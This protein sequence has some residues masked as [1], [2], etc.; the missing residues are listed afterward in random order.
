MAFESFNAADPA[1]LLNA[2]AAFRAVAQGFAYP[3]SGGRRSLV[4]AFTAVRT[5]GLPPTAR[6]CIGQLRRAWAEAA[7]AALQ[8]EYLRLFS[9]GGPVSLHETAYGDGRRIAGRAAELADIAG[10]YAAFGLELKEGDPDLP[11]HIACELEFY[12]LLLVKEAYARTRR[13]AI[14]HGVVHRAAKS[15]LEGHLGRWVGCLERSLREAGAALPYRLLGVAVTRLVQ[16]ERRRLR[17]QPAPFPGR[18]P[19][20]AMQADAF[21][22][23]MESREITPDSGRAQA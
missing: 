12:S 9:P 14:K 11:D 22:C 4:T 5:L 15:F 7:E 18:L 17:A 8:E 23:P 19:V 20:D 21:T 6:G 13:L 1:A 16:A 2:S 10:F 3:A